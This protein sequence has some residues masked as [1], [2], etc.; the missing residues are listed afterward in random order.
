MFHLAVEANVIKAISSHDSILNEFFNEQAGHSKVLC[1]TG[2]YL[3]VS[4]LTAY[5]QIR[6]YPRLI[7]EICHFRPQ[8][9]SCVFANVLHLTALL[10]LQ[11]SANIEN[12]SIVYSG[13]VFFLEELCVFPSSS[14][15]HLMSLFANHSLNSFDQ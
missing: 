13:G 5:N 10:N 9:N 4:K 8:K 6:A 11:V 12:H 7:R 14:A 1:L 15:E 2:T 3:I